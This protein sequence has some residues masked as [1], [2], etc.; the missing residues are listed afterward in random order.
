MN[1]QLTI[2]AALLL[3]IN[4]IFIEGFVANYD[5]YMVVSAE[6]QKEEE[7]STPPK[8]EKPSQDD[9]HNDVPNNSETGEQP[10]EPPENP[11]SPDEETEDSKGK[12]PKNKKESQNK[13]KEETESNTPSHQ[14]PS[15][16]QRER[17]PPN[18]HPNLAPSTVPETNT[19]PEEN[20]LTTPEAID[21][22][23]EIE[24]V[25][26]ESEQNNNEKDLSLNELK[27]L[28]VMVT[29]EDGK[30]YAIYKDD[31]DKIVKQE[32]TEKEAIELG[33]EDHFADVANEQIDHAVISMK[34]PQA[35][36]RRIFGIIAVSI[37]SIALISG[38]YLYYR[39]NIA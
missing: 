30:F 29:Q 37:L 26:E 15:N 17:T 7:N 16:H 8:E 13:K 38:T 5:E 33:Y 39:R 19:Q 21:E 10:K 31:D 14:G 35:T 11:S 36:G 1:K 25:E 12:D 18:E 4:V 23:D 28:D 2:L 20:H 32:I 6:E 3:V 27:Q 34:K 24:E 22:A 9:V